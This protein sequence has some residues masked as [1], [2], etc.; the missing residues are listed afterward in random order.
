[1][2]IL[3]IAGIRNPG[4]ATSP[5]FLP[6]MKA[7]LFLLIILTSCSVGPVTRERTVYPDGRVVTKTHCA[8]ASLLTKSESV[9]AVVDKDGKI[10]YRTK[11]M[12]E[13]TVGTQVITS[14]L[15]KKT[16]VPIA[17]P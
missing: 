8:G 17:A 15:V 14:E 10:T 1:M 6:I 3:L 5:D 13:T 2:P 4:R 7:V 11:K 16:L 9:S 12:V